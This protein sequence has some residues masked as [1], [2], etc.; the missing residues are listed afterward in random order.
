MT[1]YTANPGDAL[2]TKAGALVQGDTLILNDGT[3]L[4]TGTEHGLRVTGI[5]GT[6]D[7]PI[8]IK[9]A[10]DGKAIIDG[11]NGSAGNYEPIF[12]SDSSYVDFDGFV[13]QNSYGGVIDI[14]AGAS[15]G[16]PVDHV[17]LRRITAHHAAAGNHSIITSEFG[18]TNILIEDCAG[19]GP[20]RYMFL[21]YHCNGVT[22]R[23]CFGYWNTI[24]NNINQP[25]V[26][27]G[28]YGSQNVIEENCIGIH[29]F[30]T[31]ANAADI[32][33]S[34]YYD[35]LW[36]DSDDLI[37]FPT[38]N[39]KHFGSIFYNNWEA[40]HAN[41]NVGTGLFIKDCY[42]EAPFMSST[43]TNKLQGTGFFS[44]DPF[45]NTAQNC[46]FRNNIEGYHQGIGGATT[47]ITNG[48]FIGNNTAINGSPAHSSCD[49]FGNGALGTT[50]DGSDLTVDPGFAIATY[51]RGGALF[52]SPT[53]PLKRAGIG[54]ADIGC[55]ILYRYQNGILTQVPLWPW[56]MEDR[57]MAE[58]GIS[59]TYAAQGGIWNTLDG[60][61]TSP[62]N[63]RRRPI[64]V[65]QAYPRPRYTK[66]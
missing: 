11:Q 19:W 21:A 55:N 15:G 47:T 22:F 14:Y 27:L 45:V 30:P 35:G 29:A 23:R 24:D 39:V 34:N 52:I 58:L 63:A 49:F 44:G 50:L 8:T 41:E 56:P 4:T 65:P 46:T 54:G 25:R 37:N 18:A 51:G 3:Y 7:Y 9:A 26:G 66:K 40:F 62:D 10:N 42:F 28:I 36:H 31:D 20:G 48:L 43:K 12:V 17:T 64:V 57:V 59:P 33:D 61:Y 1:I 6:A 60:L 13:A 38:N 2:Q 16:G 5:H 53:S 32:T